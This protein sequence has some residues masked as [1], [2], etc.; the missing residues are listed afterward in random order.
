MG[1]GGTIVLTHRFH[2]VAASTARRAIANLLAL[3]QQ[4]RIIPEDIR[5]RPKGSLHHCHV[6]GNLLTLIRLR[7]WWRRGIQQIVYNPGNDCWVD[8]AMDLVPKV[9]CQHA[10]EMQYVGRHQIYHVRDSFGPS[11]RSGATATVISFLLEHMRD[12]L[13]FCRCS[14]IRFR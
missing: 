5:Q 10:N 14:R 8:E 9:T 1:Q 4:V 3:D 11:S 6:Q 12:I 13:P 2:I 7:G